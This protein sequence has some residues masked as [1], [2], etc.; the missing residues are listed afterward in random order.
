MRAILARWAAATTAAVLMVG[1]AAA[2]DPAADGGERAID[3]E[4]IVAQAKGTGAAKPGGDD[5]A[6]KYRDF[7][8]VTKGAEKIDGLF[9]LWKKDQHLYAEIKP[10][11]FN[12]PLLAPMVVSR[13]LAMAGNTL[14][15]GDEWVL[16]FKKVGDRVQVIRR[17]VRHLAPSGTPIEKAVAQN[18]TDSI[19]MA[20]PIVSVNPAGGMSTV[21]DFAD[22]FLTDFAQLGIGSLDRSRTNWH[23]VKGFPN[24]LEIQVEA[25][26]AGRRGDESV[27]DPRGTTVVV[28][29]S[30]IRLP[31]P[32]YR[33]RAADTRVGY[34]LN[35][36]KDYGSKD[37]DDNFV[38]M[39]NRWRLEKA[40]PKA[41]LSAPKKQIVWWVEDT[42][43]FEYRPYVEAG[44]RE[45]NKAFEKI[46]FA[47]AIAVRWQAPG[48]EFDPEDTSHCT[49]KW[50]TTNSTYAMSTLRSNP[51]TGEMIDGDVIFDA[52]FV[53]LWKQDYALL[54]KGVPGGDKPTA[55]VG[56]GEV[57]SPI[58][59]AREGFGL[60]TTPGRPLDPE[61]LHAVPGDWTPL[62]GALRQRMAAGFGDGH[63]YSGDCG[64]SCRFA[65]GMAYQMGLGAMAL[66]IDDAEKA[67]DDDKGK[68]K[69]GEKKD[70]PK[71]EPVPD[72][73]DEFLGQAIK[74]VVMH[75]VGHSLGL[76][77]NFKASTMLGPDELNDTAVTRQKGL[78]GSV[79][80]YAA[81]NIA[82]KGAKQGDFYTTTIGPYDYWAIEY[83]YKP[84]QGDE[85]AEL[86]KIAARAPEDDL[87]FATDEDMFGNGD[88][89][90]NTWDMGADPCQ[91]G[92]DRM[93]L[94]A[95]LLKD[96]DK[97]T[98]KDGESWARNRLAFSLLLSQYGDAA[99]LISSY[100]GGQ[101]VYRDHKGD[102]DGH[103]PVVP[104][105][106]DKQRECLKLLAT[107][108]FGDQAFR[109]EPATLRRLGVD[110][111]SHWGSNDMA[112]VDFSVYDRVLGIQR[113]ALGHCL[114]PGVLARL[115]NQELQ[116]EP[117]T[118]PLAVSEVFRAVTD[119]VWSDVKAPEGDAKLAVT[120]IRR[121][122]QREHLKRLATMV[123]GSR[124]PSGLDGL[125]YLFISG[126]GSTPA[127]ARSLAR[128]HLRE[129]DS[130]IAAALEDRSKLDDSTR[131]HL[132][133][134][135]EQIVK[136]LGATLT[137]NES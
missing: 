34:F 25:T 3:L 98:T 135:H 115:Q 121:N 43:P 22:V 74:Y 20:L 61:A 93:A 84:I 4:E 122:L 63:T 14:N 86:A 6:K 42:V 89:L 130:K 28:H 77:H 92:R 136:V 112:R 96:L 95:E 71:P 48:E 108:I 7:A 134:C 45:W 110:K 60:L 68:E 31:E 117:G 94:A 65:S 35:A 1:G 29:Y 56:H 32:G 57:L 52:G 41:K 44:I 119:G 104:I 54:V 116:A 103:D 12:Q 13:G 17:N 82:P 127:D 83:A 26:Y 64:R 38:R 87:V 72:R 100:V 50:I 124:G 11:Q 133:E 10:Q 73:T 75:E 69:D 76:R 16:V 27:I 114:S 47:E 126:G 46:G 97:R 21:V 37:P 123:L 137:A 8:E 118:K 51:L 111:W 24:N 53:K 30:L 39:V 2:Q 101:Q 70:E 99:A 90:V 107:E 81:A 129:I 128:M 33:P 79:M 15:F 120:T 19:L 102:K 49:F 59:A 109:F 55:V 78:V 66:A 85:D 132:E 125:S 58:L 18:Y 106:P 5:P 91:F 131:A 40:D 67:K 62:Q 88:P 23:K 80:D 36:T 113:I 105:D 9:T